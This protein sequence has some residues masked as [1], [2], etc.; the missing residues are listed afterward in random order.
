MPKVTQ[1]HRDARRTQIAEAALRCFAAKG[2]RGTSM[3][4][5]IAESGLSAGA[6]YGH[7]AS[8]EELFFEAAQLIM[9]ARTGELRDLR[10]DHGPLAPGEVMAT[11]LDGMRHDEI[12]PSL[13][14]QVWAEAGIDPSLREMVLGF[15]QP[16]RQLLLGLVTEW[17]AAN[18]GIAGPDPEAY[19]QRTVPVLMG[20]AP[21]FMVQRTIV[22][23]FDEDAY[24]ETV[25]RLIPN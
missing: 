13:F 2:Y 17:A 14:L 5:I 1:A 21:G 10:A 20:L 18:P 8:K 16:V 25:R 6:I 12:S 7:Y 22:A 19:A 9:S 24:L 23:D 15:L 3:A 11:V 4:D